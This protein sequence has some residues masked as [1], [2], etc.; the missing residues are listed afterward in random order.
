MNKVILM[1]NVGS[2]PKLRYYDKRPVAYFT[3]ATNEPP[4]R[5]PDGSEVP[6]RTEWHNIVCTDDLGEF[7][8]KYIRTGTRLFIEGTLRTRNWEDRTG[9]S[10]KVTEIYVQQLEI[11]GSPRRS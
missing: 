11:L 2:D 7:A 1:G 4:R 9:L 8:E 5:L 6:A 3:L 10:R